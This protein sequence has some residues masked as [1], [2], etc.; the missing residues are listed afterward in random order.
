M[1]YRYTSWLFFGIGLTALSLFYPVSAYRQSAAS[2]F[3]SQQLSPDEIIKRF[4]SRESE[5][6]EVWKEFI[7]RQETK[8]QVIGPAGTISGEFYQLSEFIFNDAGKRNERILKAPPSTLGQA[9]LGMTPEDRKAFVD[10]QPFAITKEDLP[11]YTLKYLGKEKLDD[12]STFVFEVT[13][14]LLSDARELERAR[15][16]KIEGSHFQGKVWVDDQDFQI[17]KTAGRLV[18]EFKQRFPRFETYRENINGRYWLPTYT[19]GD[20]QLIFDKGFSVHFRMV[21]RYKDYAQFKSDV[22]LLGD[23]GSDEE[24]KDRKKAPKNPEKGNEKKTKPP[25]Q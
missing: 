1:K 20:D 3:T 12:L 7:Y 18:P 4:T 22:R 9:G 13:P 5:L 6:R 25:Q 2:H 15:K 10:L 23:P 11:L 19:Y 21:I 24:E 14:K 17:V 16:Q 8:L